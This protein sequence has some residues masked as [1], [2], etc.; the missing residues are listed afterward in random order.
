MNSERPRTNLHHCIKSYAQLVVEMQHGHL[1]LQWCRQRSLMSVGCGSMAS[2]SCVVRN[3]W[4]TF[5][6]LHIGSGSEGGW[7]GAGVAAGAGAAA[8]AGCGRMTDSMLACPLG[9][10]AARAAS[11]GM[12]LACSTR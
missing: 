6:S 12:L 7:G 2:S 3:F 9:R 11:A 8:C 4:E 5:S 10:W 1:P